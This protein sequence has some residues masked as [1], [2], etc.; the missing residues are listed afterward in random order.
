MNARNHKNPRQLGL[1]GARLAVT[2]IAA[3]LTGPAI[4][5]LAA[6]EDAPRPNVLFAFADDWGHPHA[7]AYGDPTVRTPHFDRVAREGV[8][9]TR[10]FVSSP[11]CTPSRAAVLTGQHF[12][13]LGEGA[14]LHSTLDKAI[15]VYPNLL[16]D[17]GYHV[18][19]TRKGWGPGQAGRGGR[20][21]NPAGPRFRNFDE[22][23]AQ[24]PEG[25]PFCFWFGSVDPHRA[26][27]PELREKQG[28]DLDG[29]RVPAIFPDVP[30]VRADLAD[31]YAEVQRFDSEVGEIL[32]KLREMGELDNTIVV[33]SGDHGMPFPR[34]KGH[35]YD[36]GIRVPLAI[37]WQGLAPGAREVTDLVNLTDLAPTFLE[38]AGV[39]VPEEMTGQSLKKILASSDAGRVDPK[40][41]RVFFGRERHTPAQETPQSGG[42]PMRGI[43]TENFLYIR[44]FAPDR[45]PAGTPDHTRAYLEGGWLGDTDNGPTKIY[46]WANR[47][48][49]AIEPLYD[50]SFAKRPSEELYDVRRDANQITNLADDPDYAEKKAGLR[51]ELMH[52]L[53][54]SSD[55]RATGGGEN[56]DNYL[57][58]G[59]I[60][61]WPGQEEID[62][63]RA[64]EQ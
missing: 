4:S 24:R 6:D 15:P 25:A 36:S 13:R 30:A 3:A 52:E 63:Y 59:K 22:F 57:Y 46:L 31:Y 44:N 7:G 16:Q 1:A 27:Q 5:P 38:A 54:R 10:A 58:T 50:L 33:I 21:H 17:S 64:P 48:D 18:G 51:E 40:R 62:R 45:W 47:N 55:P 43:R 42:Y 9:F 35:L 53:R 29:V 28:I 34:C 61:L 41:N 39:P 56:F 32:E 8:L 37:R 60:P 12:W 49:P 20:S 14:N 19:F 11:S 23:L 26:Y 2:I